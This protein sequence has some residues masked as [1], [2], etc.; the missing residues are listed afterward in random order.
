MKGAVGRSRRK[1]AWKHVG[2]DLCVCV[3][4][5][6]CVCGFVFVCVCVRAHVMHRYIVF[7]CARACKRE[8]KRGYEDTNN[9]SLTKKKSLSI[10]DDTKKHSLPKTKAIRDDMNSFLWSVTTRQTKPF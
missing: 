5:R 8:R 3:C 2:D 9:H 10:H 7:M 4:V 1:Y 6:A